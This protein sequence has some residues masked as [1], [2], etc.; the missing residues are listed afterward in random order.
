MN[1]DSQV[2]SLYLAKKLKELGVKQDSQFYYCNA[3]SIG[4]DVLKK[5]VW[6]IAHVS[7][8]TGLSKDWFSAFTSSE[9]GELLPKFSEL[10]K[11]DKEDWICIVRPI[12]TVMT[13]HSFSPTE[14]D[15]RAKMLIYLLE[16]KEITND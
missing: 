15:A 7:Q 13:H 16:T 1:L 14:A 10:F 2:C 8:T 9:L 3:K 12:T 6:L 11:R 5:E 4:H